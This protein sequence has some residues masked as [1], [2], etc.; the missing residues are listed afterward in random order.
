MLVEISKGMYCLPQSNWAGISLS[1]ANSL[2][3]TQ[4]EYGITRLGPSPYAS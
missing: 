1:P 2:S 3:I 4:P